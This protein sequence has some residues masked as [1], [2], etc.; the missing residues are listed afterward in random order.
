MNLAKR[1]HE[2]LF[3]TTKK[4]SKTKI[5]IIVI[6]AI[7]TTFAISA[8]NSQNSKTESKDKVSTEN[9]ISRDSLIVYGK[10]GMCKSRIEGAAKKIDGVSKVK[11]EDTK[12]ML[13]YTSDGT[14]KKEDISNA[15]LKLGHD[16]ELGKAPDDIYNDLPGCCH[17]R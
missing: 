13:F 3:A 6:A 5:R 14:V 12:N 15:L 9:N 4:V 2:H 7:A 11:W 8:C 10:C 1:S 16:T 17:Y